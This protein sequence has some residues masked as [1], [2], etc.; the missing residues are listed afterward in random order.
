[1]F[2]LFFFP[3][4]LFSIF[5]KLFRYIF[6]ESDVSNVKSSIKV[7][8]PYGGRLII[9]LPNNV[10]ITIHLKD[11]KK[12]RNKKRWS[13]VLYFY[14]LFGY[15]YFDSLEK[16][17][18]NYKAKQ[19]KSEIPTDDSTF[20][21]YGNFLQSINASLRRKLENAFILTLDGDVEFSPNAIE[22]MLEKI[23]LNKKIGA[24][25]GR[26][27]PIGKGPIVWYQKFEY[28]VGHWLHK[29]TEHI[30]GTVMCSPGCFSIIRGSTIL[31]DQILPIYSSLSTEAYHYI[32]FDQGE[33]RW[34]ST[35]INQQG[36]YIVYSSAASSETFAPETFNVIIKLMFLI[37]S[38][39]FQ[40][41]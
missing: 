4:I 36:Y 13:Q 7:E 12:I 32:Q 31:E 19:Q 37:L 6:G 9:N 41:V 20:Q 2:L 27:H 10:S 38:Y 1:M 17:E 21:G 33:D 8:T 3:L 30:F 15:K 39:T 24:I 26:V 22:I 28:A 5:V 40:K 11:K 29:T 34:L 18:L 16:M 35:L 14:Y 23:V 25:C